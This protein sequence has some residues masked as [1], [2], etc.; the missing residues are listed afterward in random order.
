MNGWNIKPEIL[1]EDK[2]DELKKKRLKIVFFYIPPLHGE[3][4]I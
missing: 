3:N 2:T 4:T 1:H